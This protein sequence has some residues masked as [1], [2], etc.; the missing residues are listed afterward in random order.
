MPMETPF[1][2]SADFVL[3]NARVHIDVQSS[4]L[5][6]VAYV[7]F[8]GDYDGHAGQMV[9]H[10][11]SE[12]ATVA[13]GTEY[14]D[15]LISIC[16]AWDALH[17]KPVPDLTDEQTEMLEG[18]RSALIMVHGERFGTPGDLEDLDDADF[19]NTSDIIDSRDVIKRIEELSGAFE[20]AGLDPEAL[21]E[22]ADETTKDRA[23]EL[24]HLRALEKEAEDYAADWRYGATLIRDS[25]FVEA[26]EEQTKDIGDLPRDIPAYLAIDWE[27]TAEN[28]K[29]DYTEVDFDG[30]TYLVR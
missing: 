12:A 30:V 1:N 22:D 14:L 15:D 24:N 6:P 23:E 28:L 11:R 29:V 2:W 4:H 9:D 25:Y 8:T 20:A 13:P 5:N 27:K 26:M 18:V 7:S 16:D 3:N 10:L 17:L 21:P 19:S